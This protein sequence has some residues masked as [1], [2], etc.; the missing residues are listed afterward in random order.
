MFPLETCA[1]SRLP[2]SFFE[3]ARVSR[4]LIS[5]AVVLAFLV[6]LRT[7][8]FEFVYDDVSQVLENDIYYSS[9]VLQRIFFGDLWQ[10]ESESSGFYYRPVFL[11]WFVINHQLFGFEA[12]GWHAAS[13]LVHTVATVLVWA[14]VCS[15]SKDRLAAGM[16]AAVFAVH[17]VHIE[18]V[19][20]VSSVSDPLLS[21]FI[22]AAFLC[23]LRRDNSDNLSFTSRT[24]LTG[25]AIVLYVLALLSKETAVIFPAV[26][27]AYKF[28]T[29]E[30]TSAGFKGF[31]FR[32]Y[33]AA[34]AALPF[35][36]L[37][38]AYL[39]I[40][41]ALLGVIAREVTPLFATTVL[42]TMPK[43]IAF[44]LWHLVWPFGLS[45]FYDGIY[46]SS[47]SWSRFFLPLLI[48][49]FALGGLW[50]VFRADPVG[51]F[52]VI[53]IV[54]WLAPA[55]AFFAL[56]LGD[57]LHDRYNYIPSVGFSY[58]VASGFRWGVRSFGESNGQLTRSLPTLILLILV[59]TIANVSQSSQWQTSIAL[60]ERGVSKTALN[61]MVRNNLATELLRQNKLDQAEQLYKEVL[62][63]Q[64]EFWMSAYSL[65]QLYLRSGRYED[66]RTYLDRA[67]ELRPDHAEQYLHLGFTLMTLGDNESAESAFRSA[68]RRSSREPG[69]HH[70]FGVFLARVGRLEE[71]KQELQKE[72]SINAQSPHTIERLRQIERILK[73]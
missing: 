15:M 17:P 2:S 59:L 8:N 61:V 43:A 13:V 14:V 42:L 58:I 6:Y 11:L 32:A 55:M 36:M 45:A 25:C 23:Y 67:I 56:P 9:D 66:A 49:I 50:Y 60:Y 47:L 69:Y 12:A 70:A 24:V 54:L 65:G 4:W 41:T 20:W 29:L 34:I 62:A 71:A 44:Y 31:T 22:L 51:R 52:S 5:L 64:P 48:V 26:I 39:L 38:V 7:L 68:I 1:L 72:L 16:A 63:I 35:L 19:A 33:H 30:H 73:P 21:V 40:R 10:H 37:V 3:A 28:L 18:S 46:V 27:F 57:F 53:W